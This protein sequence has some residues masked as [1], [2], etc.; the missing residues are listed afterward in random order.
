MSPRP[1]QHLLNPLSGAGG[2]GEP[3]VVWE[4]GRKGIKAAELQSGRRGAASCRG[5]GVGG[6]DAKKQLRAPQH[7]LQY[8]LYILL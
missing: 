7:H 3:R 1:Q 8:I 6:R 2:G 5:G 4:T